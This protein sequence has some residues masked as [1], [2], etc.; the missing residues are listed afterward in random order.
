AT[1]PTAGLQLLGWATYADFPVE[2][3]QRQVDMGWGAYETFNGDGSIK[4][5]FI[6]LGHYAY[7]TSDLSFH[8]IWGTQ[9]LLGRC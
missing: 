1:P 2:F 3:A 7:F 5:V 8:A 9:P 6:P 4:G